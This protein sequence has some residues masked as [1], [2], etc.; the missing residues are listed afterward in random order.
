[1]TRSVFLFLTSLLLFSNSYGQAISKNNVPSCGDNHLMEHKNQWIP[2]Y[3]DS[4]NNFMLQV[5]NILANQV[6]P[7]DFEP[8][9]ILKVQV[10]FHI[11]HNEEAENLHDSIIHNQMTVLNE[12][13]RRQTADTASM[14]EV[15]QDIVGDS[16]IEFEL[17]SIDPQG[18]PTN[19][20]VRKAT[21][22]EYFGGVIP[23]G[24]GQNQEIE[25]W[26]NDSLY[27]NYFRI[28]DESL[29]GSNPWDIDRYLNIWIGDLR[30]LEPQFDNF[31]E[32]VF[33]ALA[34]PPLEENINWPEETLEFFAPF[35]QGIIMHYPIVGSNNPNNLGDGYQQYN[36]YVKSG[37]ILVHEVGHYL[38]L[39]HIWGDGDC[40]LDD[41]IDDTPNSNN[42]S[43]WG[44][45]KFKNTCVDDINGEDLPDMV[46]NYMDYSSGDCQN[47]FTKGQI[48]FMRYVLGEHRENIVNIEENSVDKQIKIYPNPNNGTFSIRSN[49]SHLPHK[50][51][52]FNVQGQQVYQK[53]YQASNHLEI[54]LDQPAGLYF[55]KIHYDD[56]IE[57]SKIIIY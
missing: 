15:F 16:K 19:G 10:V 43:L 31:E 55:I 12:N 40:S 54:S 41:F 46:E 30:I 42:S 34:T 27:Y 56:K 47:S 51:E 5:Q 7:L 45:D 17:A 14:R 48:A 11:V 9:K 20:I 35:T 28:T 57:S 24:P 22:I 38:G 33:F 1:M 44:C 8:D 13:F 18:N 29:G 23:Y 21:D 3:Q 2:G 50:V 25:Q 49:A 4:M 39:R 32:I 6:S 37:K 53:E 26:V 52:V 36:N